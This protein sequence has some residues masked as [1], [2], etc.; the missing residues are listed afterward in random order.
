MKHLLAA[1]GFLLLTAP[2]LADGPPKAPSQIVLELVEEAWVETKTARVVAQLKLLLTDDKGAAPAVDP[3]T[4]FQPLAAGDWQMTRFQRGQ[5]DTGFEEWVIVAEARVPQ[6]A[7]TGVYDRV[8][9]ASSRGRTM[10]ILHIDFRPSLA[11]RQATAAK[12]R[13]TLYKRAAEEAAAIGNVFPDRGFQVHRVDFNAGGMP[14]PVMMRAQAQED[15]A[16]SMDVAGAASAAGPAVSERMVMAAT[17][18][19]AADD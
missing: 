19:V 17:V 6:S 11:E 12:L 13:A 9:E 15:R 1:L 10:S 2:A 18:I 8:K 14:Q 16:S 7:L 5:T 3:R 4:M